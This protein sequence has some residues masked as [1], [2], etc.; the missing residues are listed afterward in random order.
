MEFAKY[1]IDGLTTRWEK[2][3]TAKQAITIFLYIQGWT[4]KNLSLFKNG[5]EVLRV[6]GD[7][8]I[9]CETEERVF[10]HSIDEIVELV[11][12]IYAPYM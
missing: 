3:T 8:L 6:E 12:S 5:W 10:A 9:N 1:E 7:K 2:K 11:E 4:E